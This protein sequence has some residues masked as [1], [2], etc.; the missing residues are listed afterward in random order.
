MC[1]SGNE[2]ARLQNLFFF[3]ADNLGKWPRVL[4]SGIHFQLS[5]IITV[6]FVFLV[7]FNVKKN[8]FLFAVKIS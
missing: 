2:T 3:R 7:S 6:A 8:S 5:Q 1:S 4:V